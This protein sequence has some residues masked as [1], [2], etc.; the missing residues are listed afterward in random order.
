MHADGALPVLCDTVSPHL[1]PRKQADA[2]QTTH[3]AALNMSQELKSLGGVSSIV[4]SS[5]A[6]VVLNDTRGI[7]NRSAV[8]HEQP[9]QNFLTLVFFVQFKDHAVRLDV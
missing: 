1:Q 9:H 4:S 8:T 5:E 6:L 3:Q 2:R 7:L